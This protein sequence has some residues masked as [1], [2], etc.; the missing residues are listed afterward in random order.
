MQNAPEPNGEGPGRG[1]LYRADCS[2]PGGG[3]L[4]RQ[5]VEIALDAPDGIAWSIT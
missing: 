1:V 5:E 3:W 4:S 2:V